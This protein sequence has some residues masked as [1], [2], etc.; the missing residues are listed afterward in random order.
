MHW[1]VG[2]SLR[3]PGFF[4]EKGKQSLRGNPESKS[5]LHQEKWDSLKAGFRNSEA[6][7]SKVQIH[8]PRSVNLISVFIGTICF[9]VWGGRNKVPQTSWLTI[10]I[11]CLSVVR[12]WEIWNQVVRRAVLPL[13]LW[14]ESFLDSLWLCW[15]LWI[16]GIPWLRDTTLPFLP[17][18]LRGLPMCLYLH[19]VLFSE[20]HQLYWIK[21]PSSP[22]WLHL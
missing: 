10:E 6:G 1:K 18:A 15:C 19:M 3:I 9:G 7:T 12:R 20:G 17:S 2:L 22:V 21:D 5:W 8:A 16:L 14:K 13:K 4:G 11:Y